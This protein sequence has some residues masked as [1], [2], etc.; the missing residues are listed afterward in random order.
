[1]QPYEKFRIDLSLSRNEVDCLALKQIQIY[2]CSHLGALEF[3]IKDIL[4]VFLTFYHWVFIS[5]GVLEGREHI[6][7]LC[8]AF[9]SYQ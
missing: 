1:M 6:C 3:W 5:K 9:R 4:K 8:P 2:Y 7:S